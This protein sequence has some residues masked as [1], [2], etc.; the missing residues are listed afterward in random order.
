VTRRIGEAQAAIDSTRARLKDHNE[1]LLSGLRELTALRALSP[2]ITRQVAEMLRQ[3]GG[4]AALWLE[5]EQKL[6]ALQARVV[7]AEREREDLRFQIAQL[8]GRLGILNA[9]GDSD[10]NVLREQAEQLQSELSRVLDNL[11]R[12]ADPVSRILGENPNLREALALAR[13]PSQS[14]RSASRA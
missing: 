14:P 13:S 11:A 6:S 8:K 1:P 7:G 5:T 2:E 12:T 9:E 10:L 4:T 3:L